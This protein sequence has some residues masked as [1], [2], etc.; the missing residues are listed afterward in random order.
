MALFWVGPLQLDTFP[1]NADRF[2]RQAS[3]DYAVKPVMGGLKPR[4]AMGEGDDVITLSGQLLPTKIGGL[5]ELDLADQFRM[6]QQP[7]PCQR[8][9]GKSLGWRVIDSM[10]ESHEDLQRDG[11]GFAVTYSLQLTKVPAPSAASGSGMIAMITSLF[12]ILGR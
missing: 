10:R 9:D 7:L 11:I 8:G 4:E 3:G 5:T 6:S 1:F 2:E 12:G